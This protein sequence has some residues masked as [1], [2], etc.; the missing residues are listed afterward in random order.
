MDVIG[1]RLEEQIEKIITP[2]SARNNELSED[3]S[4]ALPVAVKVALGTPLAVDGEM[5]LE[6][7]LATVELEAPF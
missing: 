1:T 4:S 7:L 2:S 3:C 6:A 5:V